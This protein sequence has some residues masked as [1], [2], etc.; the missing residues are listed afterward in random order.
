MSDPSPSAPLSQFTVFALTRWSPSQS[1]LW[2]T[3]LV[4]SEDMPKPSYASALDFQHH[5]LVLALLY[6][7]SF[8]IVSGQKMRHIFLKD[9]LSKASI[10]FLLP[11]TTRQHFEPYRKTDL[12]LLLYYSVIFVLRLYCFDFQMGSSLANAPRA[13]PSLALISF[14]AALSLL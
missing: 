9:P 7:S 13:L 6:S 3:V 14:C 4:H 12:T 11:F 10:L 1:C 8:E 5:T 2:Y